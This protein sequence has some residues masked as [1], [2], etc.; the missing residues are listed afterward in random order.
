MESESATP[1]SRLW[2]WLSR[3]G[4]RWRITDDSDGIWS[5]QI[6][7]GGKRL[8]PWESGLPPTLEI[9]PL[10]HFRK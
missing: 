7:L 3:D 1:E 6:G 8:G 5:C 9:W 4:T 10:G 2:I